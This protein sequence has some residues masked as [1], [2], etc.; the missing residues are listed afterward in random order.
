MKP[1][2]DPS[3]DLV[4]ERHADVPPATVWKAWTTPELVKRWWS[5]QRGEVTLVEID[6]RVGGKWRY[7]M[8][9]GEGLPLSYHHHM[10]TVVQTSEEIDQLMNTTGPAVRLLL[11]TGHAWF[12]GADPEEIAG[13]VLHLCSDA[14][15]FVNGATFVIDG[16]SKVGDVVKRASL[17][18]GPNGG[19]HRRWS[20]KCRSAAG[21]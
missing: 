21:A 14:A 10:G 13:T 11:D 9:A 7:V 4:L 12:G 8:V 16:E 19:S 5:G 2:I 1:A 17:S 3:L 6:L 15:S 20:W 18:I